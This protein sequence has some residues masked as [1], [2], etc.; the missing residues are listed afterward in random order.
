[1]LETEQLSA[2]VVETA[3]PLFSHNQT[4]GSFQTPAAFA[5]SWN[6]PRFA[7]PSPKKHK[8]T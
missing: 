4:I 3:Q 8:V 5:P 7:E 2:K 6:V 1:M